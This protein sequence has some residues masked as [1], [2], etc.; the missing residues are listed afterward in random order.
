VQTL[1]FERI[2]IFR[3]VNHEGKS[4]AN[5]NSAAIREWIAVPSDQ[6]FVGRDGRNL[7]PYGLETLRELADRRFLRPDDLVWTEGASEWERAD[8]VEGLFPI[9][10][11]GSTSADDA[12]AGVSTRETAHAPLAR[13]AAASGTARRRNYLRR[14]WRGELSLPVAYWVNGALGSGLLVGAIAGGAA[15]EFVRHL[16]ALGTGS[17]LLSIIAVVIGTGI[18]QSVG[19]W[20]SA[21]QHTSRGGSATWATVAK[22]MVILSIL[23]LATFSMQQV[24]SLQQAVKL[25]FEGEL[26]PQS[27]IH[28]VNHATEV[29]IAGGLSFGTTDALKTI[30]DATPTIRTVQLN[31]VGGGSGGLLTGYLH[32]AQIAELSFEQCVR[33]Y[34]SPFI[35]C[36]RSVLSIICKIKC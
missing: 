22:A 6:W 16:G 9:R 27:A 31:N 7:G 28:V 18:W 24:P 19:I 15:T 20:R 11:L 10:A 25:V 4:P 8:S 36:W 3:D 34:R 1:R 14:H 17:W 26:M 29:E 35:V 5:Y 32:S 23:R 13:E 21:E 30:L 12:A 33:N 2:D